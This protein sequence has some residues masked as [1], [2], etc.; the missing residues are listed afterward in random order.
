MSGNVFS[1]RAEREFQSVPRYT[2]ALLT[3]HFDSYTRI[4]SSILYKVKLIHAINSPIPTPLGCGKS[5][6]VGCFLFISGMFDLYSNDQ[7]GE[8]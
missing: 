2:K 6:N 1:G 4:P 8:I 5:S 3:C 7:D